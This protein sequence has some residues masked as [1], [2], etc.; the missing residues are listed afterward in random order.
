M[1]A[2]F[3]ELL[4]ERKWLGRASVG[5]PVMAVQVVGSAWD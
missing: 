4:P 3:S 5:L 1:L 2:A